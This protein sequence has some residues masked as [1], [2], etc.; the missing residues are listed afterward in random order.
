MMMMAVLIAAAILAVELGVLIWATLRLGK[1]IEVLLGLLPAVS[2]LNRVFAPAKA[3]EAPASSFAPVNGA[4]MPEKG[5]YVPKDVEG[6]GIG[7]FTD[8]GMSEQE[9]ADMLE[10]RGR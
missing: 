5:V 9:I 2:L 8:P 4:A 1:G 10:R 3:P 7:H 6:M